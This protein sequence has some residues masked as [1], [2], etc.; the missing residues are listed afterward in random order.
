[1]PS[2][3]R[4]AVRRFVLASLL[5]LLVLGVGLVVVSGQLASREAVRDARVTATR[6]AE[7]VA[8]RYL[9]DAVRAGDRGAWQ[10]MDQQ[11]HHQLNPRSIR[12]IKV[13]DPSGT[14]IWADDPGLVGRR[15]VLPA[16]VRALVGTSRSVAEVG[17]DERPAS[18]GEPV[19]EGLLEV[20][21]GAVD[22]DEVP[23][24]FETYTARGDVANNTTTIFFELAPIG[25]VALVLFAGTT[26]PMAVSLARRVDR[27]QRQRSEI[28]RQALKSWRHERRRLAQDV[29]DGVIQDLA[30]A[31]YALP[32]VLRQ[33][34]DGPEQEGVRAVGEK[35][36]QLLSGGVAQLR[37]LAMDLL[38]DDPQDRGLE[39]AFQEL[40]ARAAL[41]GVAVALAIE[42]VVADVEMLD[43][44]H[45]VAREALRNV[46]KHS[47][48][49]AATV[50]VSQMRSTLCV[51]VTDNG[52]GLPQAEPHQG[53][54]GLRLLA[55]L[56]T[57]VGGSLDLHNGASGGAVVVAMLPSELPR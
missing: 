53:S 14:V 24:V 37:G 55:D 18:G 9:N 6:L 51:R 30:A 45:R 43:L 48:A 29:H 35:I 47:G 7:D 13:W 38:P 22:D 3:A 54:M 49:T 50:T 42:P 31:G 27:G 36:S 8:G 39:A 23:F 57:E 46:V 34:P 19:H 20:Y 25:L 21:V 33:L 15:F 1:M 44:A 52:R 16:S 32:V 17:D 26:L 11:L 4:G 5:A 56:L 2:A 41:D 28:L 40:K 12:H 10:T